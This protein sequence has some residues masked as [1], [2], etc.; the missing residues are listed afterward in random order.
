MGSP[1]TTSVPHHPFLSHFLTL[2]FELFDCSEL[3]A[4]IVG[5]PGTGYPGKKD[6]VRS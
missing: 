5:E 2:A 6:S 1:L 4:M 3:I